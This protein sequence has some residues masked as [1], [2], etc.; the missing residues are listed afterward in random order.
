MIL[1]KIPNEYVTECLCNLHNIQEIIIEHARITN[2]DNI[3][4]YA[5]LKDIVDQI[6]D[7][8]EKN[9]IKGLK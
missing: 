2:R 5:T 9:G 4:E 3:P 7:D 6:E 8:A 1:V